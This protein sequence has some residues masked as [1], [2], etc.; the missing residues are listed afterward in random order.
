MVGN[1]QEK[2]VS[3]V[4]DMT[5]PEIVFVYPQ[6]G[7]FVNDTDLTASWTS[8]GG[9][10][11]IVKNEVA[12]DDGFYVD[13]GLSQTHLFAGISVGQHT[14]Y[15]RATDS[16][17]NWAMEHVFFT[18]DRTAPTVVSH[19]PL[20]GAIVVPS[21]AVSVNFSEVMDHTSVVFTGITGT[22]TWNAAG[23]EVTIAHATFAYA[24]THTVGVTAKD[25]AGNAV[26][27]SWTFKVVT[28]VTG[29]VNDD[30]GNPIANA[31][32]KISQGSDVVQGVTDANGHFAL[33]VDGV[34]TY[35]LTISATGFQDIVKTDQ[36]YGVEQTNALGAM[37]MTP[38]ADYTLLIV[39][40]VAVLAVVLAALFLMRRRKV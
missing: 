8:M 12:L 2:T 32:V 26:T 19:S 5:A 4:V 27:G 28:Q 14:I 9:L 34:G 22:M 40:V 23:N 18:V 21:Y 25:R 29:T 24:T 7:W 6:W 31:T 38:N 17:G 13:V 15:V 39:G 10:S 3:I 37:A 1:S 20:S 11:L 33:I 30:K 16:A 35:N 36:A